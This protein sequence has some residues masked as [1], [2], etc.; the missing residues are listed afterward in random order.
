MSRSE[1]K[2]K[3][4]LRIF[5]RTPRTYQNDPQPIVYV[6]EFFSFGALGMIGV[7]SRGRGSLR[8]MDRIQLFKSILPYSQHESIYESRCCLLIGNQANTS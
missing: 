5:Q 8:M 3:M 2:K 6:W 4:I 7:C 1:T